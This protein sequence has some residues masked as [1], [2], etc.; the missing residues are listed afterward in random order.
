VS[1]HLIRAA[2][3]LARDDGLG[4]L[5]VDGE[6]SHPPTESSEL[7]IMVERPERIE[8]LDAPHERLTRR[9]I[10]EVEPNKVVDAERLEEEDYRCEVRPLNLGDRVGLEFILKRPL[11][12]EPE[13]LAGTYTSGAT[14]SLICSSARALRARWIRERD[15]EERTVK[16]THGN[17]DE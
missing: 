14:G 11:G 5:R 10:E 9:R 16:K 3:V 13:A 8:Q 4:Q 6:L 7:A 17:D 1:A 12:E 2:E 15:E